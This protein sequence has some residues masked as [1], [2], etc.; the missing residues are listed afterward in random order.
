MARAAPT[1]VFET[2]VIQ[3]ELQSCSSWPEHKI[4]VF[5]LLSEFQSRPKVVLNIEVWSVQR[6]EKSAKHGADA[7]HGRGDVRA[8]PPTLEERGLSRHNPRPI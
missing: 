2:E 8:K 3:A 4:S 7:V 1:R 5:Y 6:L